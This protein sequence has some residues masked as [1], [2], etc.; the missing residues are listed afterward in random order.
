[1]GKHYFHIGDFVVFGA[2][3]LISIAIGIY[4][5]FSGGRQRT[6]AEYLVGGRTMS[7]I[8][9]AISLMVSFESSI[10]MLGLPA[11]AYVYGI[12]IIFSSCGF[13]ISNLLSIHIVVPLLHPLKITSAYE[14]L[15]L[16]F[17]SRSVRLVGTLMG[18]LT[19]I[20][21]MG[22]VLFGPAVA[23][24]AVTDFPLWS[25]IFIIELVAVIYTAFG[26]LKAVIWTD[27]FQA[28]VM[29][30]GIFAILIKGTI[31]AGGPTAVWD[32]AY[33]GGRL[34]FFNFDP[35]P[36]TRHTFWNL[37]LGAIVR[38]FGLGFNQSTVQR[39]SSTKTINDAKRMLF[40]VAP[41]F[42]ISLIISAYEGTVAYAYYQ[43]KGCD[44]F[45]SKQ[46]NDPNQIV[47]YMVMDIFEY[48]PGMP[49]LFLAALFSASLST[50]SSGL[51][52][53]SALLWA[54]V[55]HPL[56]GPHISETK[57]TIIAKIAVLCFGALA[58]GVAVLVSQIGGTLTQISGSLIAAFGGPLIGI[59]FLGCFCPRSN[60]KGAIAGG[61]AGLAFAFWMSLGMN[62][63]PVIKKTPWL[64][65]A[66]IANCSVPDLG[67]GTDLWMSSVYNSSSV[68]SNYTI[69]STVKSITERPFR[70]PEGVEKLYTVSY[71]WISVIGTLVTMVV[72]VIVSVFTGMN[73]PGDVDP[74]YLISVSE[75]LLIFLPRPVKRY[76]SSIGPQYIKEEYKARFPDPA[77]RLEELD[78]EVEIKPITDEKFQTDGFTDKE[79]VPFLGNKAKHENNSAV[80]E[81]KHEVIHMDEL[82]RDGAVTNGAVVHGDHETSGR[83]A[84]DP[85]DGKELN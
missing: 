77:K 15:E 34:N 46:I 67:N 81:S 36:R 61:F 85:S 22:I 25:S 31:D 43:A 2:T 75:S 4:Y 18:M 37:F 63:S 28:F 20:W 3:I 53:L 49:G 70:E 8:P 52:S 1:M 35:D 55:V 73:K 32:T 7:F 58:C 41:C 12:Q 45:E 38:G 56:V 17:R 6:T 27:V 69:L 24:E 82:S 66:S 57:A 19:Y 26:G 65:P 13:L 83:Q 80:L 40:S 84:D 76:L 71:L 5:A 9:V 44:P 48:L 64:P 42:T 30:A 47:P 16:R 29:F 33:K 39:I 51:S 11:E 74:R 59:F 10:M 54:D 21:Y 78:R 50:L 60:E 62:F 68:Y 79:S 72:G 14:Y 23:L